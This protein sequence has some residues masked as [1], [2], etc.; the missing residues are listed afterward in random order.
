MAIMKTI[1]HG[2]R[3]HSSIQATLAS[4][5]FIFLL[6]AGPAAFARNSPSAPA[7]SVT[8]LNENGGNNAI[9]TA[10]DNAEAN[11]T[12]PVVCVGPGVYPEQVVITQSGITLRGLGTYS[13]PTEIQP[14]SVSPNSVSPDSSADESNIILVNGVSASITGVTISNIVVD[15]SLASSSFTDCSVDYEGILFL[16]AGGSIINNTVQNILLPAPLAGCQPGNAIEV[17]TAATFAST[18]KILRDDAVNYNKNG[19]TCN[20]AAT[21]CTIAHNKVSFYTPYSQYIAPNGIQIGFGALGKVTHNVVSNNTC[22]LSG[23]CGPD[24][25]TQSQGSG[26]L[27]YGS[28]PGTYAKY[29]TLIGNDVGVAVADDSATTYGNNIMGSTA[30]GILAY[31]GEGTYTFAKNTLTSNPIG[32]AVL[33]DGSGGYPGSFLSNIK[34]NTFN[35]D[36]VL[37][38]IDTISPGIAVVKYAGHTITVSGTSTVNIT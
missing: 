14:T 11:V 15:G 4:V 19:I 24:I 6:G 38:Q 5:A 16:N 18:V 33:S 3:H 1:K 13:N 35:S 31:D 17:Q 37:I 29:N 25:L 34:P 32:V 27:T 26:V 22:T 10:V 36:T 9:Q 30:A 2:F 23:V 20:D 21:T 8:I 7:C 28:A 12:G